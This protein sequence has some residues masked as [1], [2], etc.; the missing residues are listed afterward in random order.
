[1]TRTMPSVKNYFQKVQ[2]LFRTRRS[3][4]Q[5]SYKKIW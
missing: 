1:M 5:D 2:A 3:A 4:I